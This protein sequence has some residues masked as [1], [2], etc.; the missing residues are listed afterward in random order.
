MKTIV[1][2]CALGKKPSTIQAVK[3]LYPGED[4]HIIWT[5]TSRD[6]M[7][8]WTFGSNLNVN[9][10]NVTV[11][12]A[13]SNSPN[14][15]NAS[16]GRILGNTK[17]DLFVFEYCSGLHFLSHT[18]ANRISNI[19]KKYSKNNSR[20]ITHTGKRNWSTRLNYNRTINVNESVNREYERTRN[21][22]VRKKAIANRQAAKARKAAHPNNYNSN[23]NSSIAN[24]SN[25]NNGSNRTRKVNIFKFL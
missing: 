22:I 19:L 12:I 11:P 25:N 23:N 14:A 16:L 15:F 1:V 21:R 7:R 3:K 6:Y 8:N 4:T 10:K 2:F 9:N 17:V 13:S 18:E 24:V 5:T 20:V